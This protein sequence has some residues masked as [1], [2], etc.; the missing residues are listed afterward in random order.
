MAQQQ[1]QTPALTPAAP[2]RADL[3]RWLTEW[4][5]D[6]SFVWDDKLKDVV[7]MPSFNLDA[8]DAI[9]GWKLQANHHAAAMKQLKTYEAAHPGAL[10]AATAAAISQKGNDVAALQ[11]LSGISQL[12]G[13]AVGPVIL[14]VGDPNHWTVTDINANRAIVHLRD[15][16]ATLAL[17]PAHDLHPLSLLLQQYNPANK[18]AGTTKKPEYPAQIQDWPAYLGVCRALRDL[19]WL[20][21]RTIDRALFSVGK[22]L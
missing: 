3:T 22:A 16:F 4:S 9:L 1:P 15:H 18:N 17:P 21:L 2:T 11:K 13:P 14:M 5:L 7:G 8:L 12:Q 10:V 19:T 20:S 6:Y